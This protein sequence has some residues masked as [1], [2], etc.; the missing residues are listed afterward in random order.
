M[1]KRLRRMEVEDTELNKRKNGQEAGEVEKKNDT[2]QL[3]I[4]K[5]DQS[6]SHNNRSV[7]YTHL[8]VYKRQ[9][10]YYV[11]WVKCSTSSCFKSLMLPN[12][13]VCWRIS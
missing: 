10:K 3:I 6:I 11:K 2:I 12:R 4:Q 7:S 9:A 1:K 5:K 13:F 8:D